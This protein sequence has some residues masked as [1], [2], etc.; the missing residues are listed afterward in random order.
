MQDFG[1]HLDVQEVMTL[2]TRPSTTPTPQNMA[3]SGNFSKEILTK[4]RISQGVAHG[5]PR[6]ARLRPKPSNP[7]ALPTKL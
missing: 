1:H 2:I 3:L 4:I 6:L 5:L 7:S